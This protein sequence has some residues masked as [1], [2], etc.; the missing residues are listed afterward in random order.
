MVPQQETILKHTQ[1][2]L[3]E[4]RHSCLTC[5]SWQFREHGERMVCVPHGFQLPSDTF[6]GGRAGQLFARGKKCKDWQGDED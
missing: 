6:T 1:R 3:D 4:K 5:I 2:A